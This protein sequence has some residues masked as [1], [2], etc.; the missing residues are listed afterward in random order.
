MSSDVTADRG[1]WHFLKDVSLPS[2]VAGVLAVVVSY[3]GPMVTP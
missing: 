2:V 3:P 1:R